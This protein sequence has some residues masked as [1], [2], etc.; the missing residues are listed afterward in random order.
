MKEKVII[1]L[2]GGV[3]S[4]VALILLLEA[5]YDVE[6]CFMRNWDS[7]ANNDILGN[8]DSD[9]AICPQE[10]DYQDALAV[11]QKLNVKLHRVDFIKEYWEAVFVFFLDELKKGR[12]PNPDILCNKEIKFK[13]FLNYAETLGFEKI[14]MGHYADIKEVNG[15]KYLAKA[16]DTNK[17]QTY[18]LSQ[19]SAKQIEKALFPLG[20]LLKSE[21]REI[22]LKHDLITSKKKDSTGICFIGERNFSK[23]LRNYLPA[24][25]GSIKTLDGKVLGEH[26]GLM[27]YTIGQRKGIQI[28]GR[29]D[30]DKDA[31]YV[32]GK[33][34]EENVLYAGQGFENEYLYADTCILEDVNYLGEK[35][36]GEKALNAKF[37]YRAEEHPVLIKFDKKEIL[38]RFVEPIR[39]VTPGQACVFYQNDICLGGGTIKEVFRNGEK[40]KY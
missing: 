14:A 26:E 5:G 23:F 3:D 8:P 24:Q 20:K 15:K 25:K 32:L 12:T 4:S 9:N 21:V 17:D 39:A 28:G 18:F 13:A 34:I 22:A 7:A 1:G 27:N 37:R 29:N 31:W 10:S 2:S 36:E 11:A 38:V 35:F 40:R 6:A 30:A 19:L 33:N 16:S